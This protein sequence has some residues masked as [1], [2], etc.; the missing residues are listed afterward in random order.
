MAPYQP[1]GVTSHPLVIESLLIIHQW[2]AGSGGHEQHHRHVVLQQ[3]GW[4]GFVDPV[5]GGLEPLA[6]MPWDFP[7]GAAPGGNFERKGWT[8]CATDALRITN[9]SYIRRWHKVSCV[10][11]ETLGSICLPPPRTRNVSASVVGVSKAALALRRVPH[12]V[13]LRRR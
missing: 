13:V 10:N 2:E 6:G 12:R 1:A 8:N 4:A 11:R 9:G 5:P 3:P 7:G